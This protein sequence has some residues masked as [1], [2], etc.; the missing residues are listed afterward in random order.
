[1]KN[2]PKLEELSI[3]DKD[4]L[5]IELWQ[6]IQNL[7]REIAGQKEVPP[8][9][10]KNSSI[11]PSKGFKDNIKPSKTEKKQREGHKKGGR[12]LDNEPNQII[13]AQAKICPNCHNQLEIESQALHSVYEKIEVPKITALVTQIRQYGGECPI[14][15]KSI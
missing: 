8:K 11:P 14:V 12:E 7:R 9:I 4:A 1:M 6:E 3:D 10:K 5:I 2:L 13:I 15:S